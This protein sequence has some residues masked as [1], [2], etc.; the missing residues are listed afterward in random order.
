MRLLAFVACTK[1]GGGEAGPRHSWTQPGV[2]RVAI[3]SD[4]KNLNPLL[5]SNTT[6]GF[7]DESDFRAAA[8]RRR[9]RVIR[10][11]MLATDGADA[12]ERRRQPRRPDDHLSPAPRREM[13]RRRAGDVGGRQVVV[14]SDHEPEQQHR[15]AA[16][17]RLRRRAST[18]RTHTRSSSTS[19][20]SSRRSSTRS[21][22]MSDQPYAGRAGTRPREISRHQSASVQQRPRRQRR[23]LQ[24]R[25]VGARRPHRRRAQRRFL[26]GQAAPA[27]RSTSRSFPTRTRPSTCCKTHAID[28]MFQASLADLSGAEVARPTSDLGLR[29]RQRL[30]AHPAEHARTRFLD[31]PRVR[32]AIAYAIDKQRLVDTL[33][34]GQMNGRHGRH[35]GLDVGVQPERRS[36][37]ARPR[38][39]RELLREPGWRPGPRRHH[40]QERR[41]RSTSCWSRITRTR[42]GGRRALEVQAMLREAGIDV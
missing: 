22:P 17:L 40:A 30:R 28:F 14:A 19:S 23:S 27:T 36:L 13:D 35:S 11:P 10:V 42:R 3:Q 24:V 25:R 5:N 2:L 9:Q 41:C 4:V 37:S 12:R 16:R 7:I 33:T 38:K 21:S 18:R 34:Y 6:D 20:R 1:T 39:A 8:H 29:Q 26:H 32:Q 31:D 15:F